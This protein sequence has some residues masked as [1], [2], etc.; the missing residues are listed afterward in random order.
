MIDEAERNILESDWHRL[1]GPRPAWWTNWLS[2]E[3][4]LSGIPDLSLSINPN[5]AVSVQN[6]PADI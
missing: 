2:L 1:S 6:P 5:I 3:S 4:A